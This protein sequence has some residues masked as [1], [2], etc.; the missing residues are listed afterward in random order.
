M[1]LVDLVNDNHRHLVGLSPSDEIRIA[2]KV[3]N[4]LADDA[5]GLQIFVDESCKA[6]LSRLDYLVDKTVA[7]IR[8]VLEK[9]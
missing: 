1:N 6:M 5:E 4:L 3:R 9:K 7:D 8:E 2:A